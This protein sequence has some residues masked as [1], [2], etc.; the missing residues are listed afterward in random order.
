ML[1]AG[2]IQGLAEGGDAAALDQLYE[3]EE[4]PRRGPG[5]AERGVTALDLRCFP[6][7]LQPGRGAALGL[8]DLVL[9]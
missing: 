5:V 1:P 7:H 2:G 3:V 8:C 4:D 6:V 9:G